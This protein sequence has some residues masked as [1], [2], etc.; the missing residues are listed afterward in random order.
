[1]AAGWRMDCGEARQEAGKLAGGYRCVP[2]GKQGW[3]L[4][5]L[6]GYGDAERKREDPD[7][8]LQEMSIGPAH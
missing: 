7:Y 1:M 2:G 6:Q 8:N 4:L 3:W 5:G